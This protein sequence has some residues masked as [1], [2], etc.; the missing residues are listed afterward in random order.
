MLKNVGL[1]LASF[2]LSLLLIEFLLRLLGWS[3]PVFAQPDADLGWS[4]RPGLHGWAVHENTAYLRLNRLAFRGHEWPQRANGFRIAVLGDS[5]VESSNLPEEHALTTL[6]ER[7]LRACPAFATGVEVLNLGVSGYGTAQEYVLLRQRVEP[8]HADMVLLAFYAGN[9]VANNIRALSAAGQMEKPYFT[10]SAEGALHLDDGFRTSAAFRQGVAHDW[11]HRM[12]NASYLLQAVKQVTL[13]RPIM[14]DPKPLA[15]VHL[16]DLPEPPLFAPEYAE[17]FAPPHNDA[18]ASAWSV[19]ER[20]LVSMRDWAQAQKIQFG[21]IIIP[22]PV[23]VLPTEAL[24]RRATAKFGLED[25]DYPV[26]RIAR[27]AT[28]A[29]ISFLDLRE[30]LRTEGDVKRVFLYGFAPRYGDGHLNA[31][32]NAVSGDAVAHWLCQQRATQQQ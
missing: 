7:N 28:G 13:G 4:F 14:P 20:L 11:R 29:G 27:A 30:P 15:P 16:A 9:D 31:T 8:L 26:E 19:T 25:L 5:F 10:V 12:I 1:V 21:I 24:R 3:F 6:I 32:G 18:W 22:A 23:E 17:L 2:V